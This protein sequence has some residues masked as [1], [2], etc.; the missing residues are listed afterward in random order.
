MATESDLIRRYRG[1]FS[2]DDCKKIIEYINVF[3]KSKLLINDRDN[4]HQV[5]HSTINVAYDYDFPTSSKISQD[6]IP[7]FEPCVQE[8]M[9]AFS[10]L[11]QCQF[12]IYDLK[13]KKIP[14]GG[15]F[16]SWHFENSS[17]S[18]SQRTFVI[19]ACPNE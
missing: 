9:E 19:S 11:K 2:S 12:L 10:I 8:Y 16:H 15:G 17:V 18:Y 14:M 5:D 3:E 6:I 4:L 1:A 7:N 13:L